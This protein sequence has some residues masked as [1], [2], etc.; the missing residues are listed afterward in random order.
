MVRDDIAEF[1]HL[2][3]HAFFDHVNFP[4]FVFVAYL[5]MDPKKNQYLHHMVMFE[6]VN[7]IAELVGAV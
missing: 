2:I 5:I 1:F 4:N 3:E 7:I 6:F